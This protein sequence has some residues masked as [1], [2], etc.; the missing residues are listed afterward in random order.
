MAKRALFTALTVLVILA[1]LVTL[2][3]FGLVS[4]RSTDGGSADAAGQPEKVETYSKKPETYNKT[5]DRWY[6]ARTEAA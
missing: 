4:S 2:A 6:P 3:L 1:L 5:Y